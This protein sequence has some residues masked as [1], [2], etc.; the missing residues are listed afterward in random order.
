MM[1]YQDKKKEQAPVKQSVPVHVLVE[2]AAQAKALDE[3]WVQRS[4]LTLSV[5]DS[6]GLANA[7]LIRLRVRA[8]IETLDPYPFDI[9]SEEDF[10]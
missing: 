8:L 7:L 3:E 1:G 5:V 9:P 2:L 6:P 4:L 10:V